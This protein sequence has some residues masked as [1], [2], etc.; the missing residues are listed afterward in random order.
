MKK[1][2][3]FLAFF[4]LCVNSL[5]L[6]QISLDS[7]GKRIDIYGAEKIKGSMT[8]HNNSNEDV[9]LKAKIKDVKY[10]FPF[11]GTKQL[12]LPVGATSYSC[13]TW[14]QVDPEAFVV[15]AKGQKVVNYKISVPV[16]VRGGYYG[17]LFFEEEKPGDAKKTAGNDELKAGYTFFLEAKDRLKLGKVKINSVI[18][19]NV[20][21]E[22]VNLGDVILLGNP[23]FEIVNK[24]NKVFDMGQIDMFFLPP[25][26]R[27]LFKLTF[28]DNLGPGK[29]NLVVKFDFGGGDVLTDKISFSKD[30]S[31]VVSIS[32]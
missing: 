8:V 12:F 29:Y 3:L 1:K 22:I 5:V 24:E 4:V 17:T 27:A 19:N 9:S 2:L 7:S 6:A 15:P 21:G 10:L 28:D 25:R 13:G 16:K 23:S 26:E 30:P 32:R 11:D 14:I 18:R 20:R 31:G